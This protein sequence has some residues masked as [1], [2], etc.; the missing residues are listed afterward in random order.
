MRLEDYRQS[1]ERLK[2]ARHAL[3]VLGSAIDRSVFDILAEHARTQHLHQQVM[4][5]Q[6]Q[7]AKLYHAIG[8]VLEAQAP[9]TGVDAEAPGG[10]AGEAPSNSAEND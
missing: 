7:I 4:D 1:D 3:Y 2:E 10:I 9:S 5:L 6:D 8:D